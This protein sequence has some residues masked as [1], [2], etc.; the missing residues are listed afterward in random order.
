M[1]T[2]NHRTRMP[3]LGNEHS[4]TGRRPRLERLAA[5][6]IPLALACNDAPS[7]VSRLPSTTFRIAAEGDQ[8]VLVPRT[9]QLFVQGGADTGIVT[10]ASSDTAIATVSQ[11]GVVT[12]RFPGVVI[13]TARRGTA[14]ATL[15]VPARASTID[16]SPSVTVLTVAG[17]QQ[18]KAV[19]RDANGAELVGVPVVWRI[20]NGSVAR[21][22]VSTG[23]LTGL[24]SG[25]ATVSAD[26]GGAS[27]DASVHVAPR[28]AP[29]L[30]FTSIG[31]TGN[32][33]CGLEEATGHAYCWGDNHAG[34][35]GIGQ[36]A[37]SDYPVPVSGGRHFRVLS[38]GDYAT[39][40]I[41][42]QTGLAYCWGFNEFGD[43]GDGSTTIRWDPTAVAGAKQ[44]TEISAS[45]SHTCAVEAQTAL[46]YCWGRAGLI[47]DN[48]TTQ[49]QTPTLVGNTAAPIRFS[50]VSAGVSHSCG[51]EFDTGAAYCWG[52]ND[53]GQ[54]GNAT[55][56]ERL[57]PTATA[58]TP[59]FGSI[60]AGESL[61]CGVE[62]LTGFGY[63]WGLNT[64]GQV[65]DGS[66]TN[67][68]VPTLVGQGT[69]RFASISAT[70]HAHACGLEAS[71]G[72]A[73][74]WGREVGGA[75]VGATNSG[76]APT[77]VG[78]GKRFSK[79]A[80]TY[81]GGC[82]VE[83]QTGLGFCWDV[84]EMAARPV[85]APVF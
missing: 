51:I 59:R 36:G 57:V 64:F 76:G 72:F 17:A 4:F 8:G 44:F 25:D 84:I 5:L 20:N 49:R 34:A 23:L 3:E 77:L 26:A 66:T 12:G 28:F 27:G 9:L 53:A 80:A 58:G 63:C 43:L 62:T 1:G 60:S 47:G 79:I 50:S 6:I 83:L 18:L 33:V 21:I 16:I 45:G 75:V 68:L 65:G 74:C 73:Y 85:L 56:A 7:A 42:N 70:G 67:R 10:W 37:G 32:H 78:G 71:T 14:S 24:A 19:V 46:G 55:T 39:C 48:S 11:L 22:D 15:G 81:A 61:S 31:S 69:R 13:I 38:V 29:P 41:E 35:L 82:G 2:H 52:R 40:G 30:A 54:L